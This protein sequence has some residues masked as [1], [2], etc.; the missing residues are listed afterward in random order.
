M[1]LCLVTILSL[2]FQ[3]CDR[4]EPEG[5]CQGLAIAD[6]VLEAIT[7]IV[8]SQL[9]DGIEYELVHEM[10]NSMAFLAGCDTVCGIPA[11]E[12]AHTAAENTHQQ[13][14]YYS[15]SQNYSDNPEQWGPPVNTTEATVDP[16]KGCQAGT[17]TYLVKFLVDGYYLV[18]SIVDAYD[19]IEEGNEENNS[20]TKG[21]GRTERTIIHVKGGLTEPLTKDG[22]PVYLEVLSSSFSY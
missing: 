16:L 4:I 18:E 9:P 21:F 19:T 22:S 3:S 6:L 13:V 14:I 11:E 17:L 20:S 10:T 5:F 15:S 2:S 12:Q 7:P 8:Q 1:S